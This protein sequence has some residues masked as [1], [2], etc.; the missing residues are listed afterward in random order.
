MQTLTCA[1]CH[2]DMGILRDARVRKG[3]V[4]YCRECDELMQQVLRLA[5]RPPDY[6]P[7]LPDCLKGLF[8]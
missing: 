1:H 2:K 8:K 4:V 3:M 7:D 6:S 5:K